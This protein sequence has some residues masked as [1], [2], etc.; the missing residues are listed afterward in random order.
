MLK[1]SDNYL[2]ANSPH[3]IV[4]PGRSDSHTLHVLWNI[5]MYVMFRNYHLFST[6]MA[7]PHVVS[8]YFCNYM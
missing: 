5:I 3:S 4:Q 1:V 8:A 2:T 7:A 6:S